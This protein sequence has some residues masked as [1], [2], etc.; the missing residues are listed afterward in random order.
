M[1]NWVKKM[2]I[3]LGTLLLSLAIACSQNSGSESSK[4]D[5]A[6]SPDENAREAGDIMRASGKDN[7]PLLQDPSLTAVTKEL[8]VTVI[9]M[10]SLPFKSELAVASVVPWSS[11][12][13]P[14][15]EKNLFDDSEAGG[16]STLTKYDLVRRSRKPSAGSAAD[17]ERQNFKPNALNWEGLCDAWSIASLSKPEPK[18]AV[19]I[20]LAASHKLITF[21]IVDLKAL[22]LK[23][24]EAVDDNNFKYYGQ[25]FTGNSNGWVFPD[26]F[27]DQFH[28]FL[29]VQLFA[30]RQAFVMDHD[31]GVEVWNVPVYKANYTMEAI[32]NQPNA[33]LVKAWVF[34]AEQVPQDEKS[35]V[36]TKE[37]SRQYNYILTGVRDANNNLIVKAGYWVKSPDGI[38][39]RS[40]HPD[41]I[42]TINDPAK[43]VRKSWNPEID[44]DLIDEIL[45]QSY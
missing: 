17:Y 13:F 12:W 43:T 29:E 21:D 41:Y 14:Q 7:S 28:R 3:I 20:R 45:A 6:K 22:M 27:P 2:R 26:I 25:K 4:I 40:D 1:L 8:G 10:A 19:M 5:S 35:F 34:S 24:Y 42:T 31:P 33:V 44:I 38:D 36:G 39:S 15:K 30:R 18:H 11:W 23:T 32:P 9:S 37:A 16:M